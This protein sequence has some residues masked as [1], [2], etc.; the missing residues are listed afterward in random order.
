MVIVTKT[1]SDGH[2]LTLNVFHS[3]QAEGSATNATVHC[4]LVPESSPRQLSKNSTTIPASLFSIQDRKLP[5][6]DPQRAWSMQQHTYR[7]KS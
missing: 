4:L 7:A 2:S 6:C 1:L 5:L 3:L